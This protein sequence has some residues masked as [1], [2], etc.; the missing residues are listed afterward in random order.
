MSVA[1]DWDVESQSTSNSS[2]RNGVALRKYPVHMNLKPD[3]VDSFKS[4]YGIDPIL[5]RSAGFHQHPHLAFERST[6]EFE[7]MKLI[8][9]LGLVADV[10]SAARLVRLNRRGWN[11]HCMNPLIQPGDV[12]R[13]EA[14]RRQRASVC[15]HRLQDCTH[16]PFDAL[17]FVHSCYYFTRDELF[18]ALNNTT[19]KTAVVVGHKFG[20]AYGA[21]AGE[22]AEYQM[23]IE[24]GEAKITM[25]VR[26]NEY[27]YEHPPLLW[28][29]G[30]D[31]HDGV[32]GLD[33]EQVKKLGDTYLWRV[34]LSERPPRL[35]TIAVE[36]QAQIVDKGHMGRIMVPGHVSNL[37]MGN[38][39]NELREIEV[40]HLF[41]YGPLLYTVT[42]RGHVYLPK[43]LVEN[44]AVRYSNRPRDP[45]TFRDI[46][47]VIK[48]GVEVS[49]LPPSLQG[50]AVAL[51][52]ALAMNWNVQN[53]IDMLH[54]TTSRFSAL[55]KVHAALVSLS[56]VRVISIWTLVFW[57]TI[58]LAVGIAVLVEVPYDHHIVGAVLLFLWF[59]ICAVVACSFCVA[60]RIQ[61]RAGE[62]WTSTLFHD[63]Q[64]SSIVGDSVSPTRRAFPA[65]HNLREPLVPPEGSTLI[66]GVDP[67][68]PRHP[69]VVPTP[70]LLGGGAHA[71]TVPT[72]PPDNQSAEIV[73]ITHRVLIGGTTVDPSAARRFT[74]SR[75][76]PEL[77]ALWAIRIVERA[78]DFAKWVDQDKFSANIRE[79]FCRL[80]AEWEDRPP[81]P[82]YYRAFTKIEKLKTTTADGSDVIKPR[83]ISGPWDTVKVF[84]GP[85]MSQVYDGVRRVWNGR[86][87]R[88]LYASGMTPDGIGRVCDEF[89]ESC[90]GWG[91][92]GA[93]WDDAEVYDSTLQ[94]ELKEG[95]RTL[96]KAMGISQRTLAW[97]DS[98]SVKGV[99]KHGVVYKTGKKIHALTGKEVEIDL[100]CSGEMDTNVRGTITNGIAHVNAY[101]GFQSSLH[102]LMLVCGDDNITFL[103]RADCNLGLANHVK[104]ELERLGLKVKQGMSFERHDW[105]FCSKLFWWGKNPTTGEVQTVLGPKPGRWLTRIGFNTST[106]GAL[107][108]R[109][110]MIGSRQDVAHIPML[111]A[112]VNTGLR[113][114]S[115]EKRT[116]SEWSE[117]K[118]V[119]RAFSEV[120]ANT[121]L[122]FARYKIGVE[123]LEEYYRMLVGVQVCPFVLSFPWIEGMSK[124]DA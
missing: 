62:T 38:S 84:L 85:F 27:P 61:L 63:Q 24:N 66:V 57:G 106:A 115:H 3:V 87:S 34:T 90:G 101:E 68:P 50:A 70:L 20:D 118:H 18:T 48:K 32:H 112:Y 98:T 73:A 114:S 105:E 76:A 71:E 6:L 103:K 86:T 12:G 1:S 43:G 111:N 37:S 56:P 53:E 13:L 124:V 79:K 39:A 121:D 110:A 5:E 49:R 99:T 31:V 44:A 54:T 26:G 102:Y 60:R 59:V 123:H 89:A 25:S 119:S 100:L 51:G 19:S 113:V 42:R 116:G 81:P 97:F 74:D 117:F 47:N 16:G 14:N 91:N 83:L 40:D 72:V 33:V 58:A 7:G 108:F 109:G 93:I 10:G 67:R 120:P 41:G 77:R 104:T 52:T 22:E 92:V 80:R 95:I 55:W 2:G 75:V 64:A 4:K 122:L 11:I 88:V 30:R 9:P 65:N 28:D 29:F 82:S 78:D 35:S 36:W 23:F 46:H 94:N 15:T 17:L 96:Y 21:F 69:G 107:N 45:A 8:A